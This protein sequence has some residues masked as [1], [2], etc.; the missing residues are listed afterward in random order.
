VV[1][2]LWKKSF[3]Y[4]QSNDHSQEHED[5]SQI[6]SNHRNAVVKADATVMIEE[7]ISIDLLVM[8]IF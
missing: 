6:A 8:E 7:Q 1:P 4:K 3:R 2:I 5:I